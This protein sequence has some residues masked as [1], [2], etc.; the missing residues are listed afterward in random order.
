[1]EIWT[2]RLLFVSVL[3][4]MFLVIFL[5]AIPRS[6]KSYDL[7]IK[8]KDEKHL[9]NFFPSAFLT[10]YFLLAIFALFIKKVWLLT[11]DC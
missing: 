7:W 6:L 11:N 1:M 3:L 8:T 9:S 2:Y 4:L 10:L 5:L